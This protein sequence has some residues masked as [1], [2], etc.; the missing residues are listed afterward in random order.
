MQ[1]R[2]FVGVGGLV[3]ALVSLL[4]LARVIF[5]VEIVIGAV[6]LPVWVSGAGFVGGGFLA[7]WAGF[8]LFGSGQ[9]QT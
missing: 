4:H 5:A 8:I 2:T 6:V 9:P 3:F 1:E 7:I